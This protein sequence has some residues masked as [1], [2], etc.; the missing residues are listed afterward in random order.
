MSITDYLLKQKSVDELCAVGHLIDEFDQATHILDGLPEEYALVVMNIAANN[1]FAP[2]SVAYVHGLLLNME[3]RITRHRSSTSLGLE[4]T[5][6]ALLTPIDV[7]SSNC[8]WGSDFLPIVVVT[9]DVVLL[10]VVPHTPRP[11]LLPQVLHVA[12]HG[13]H[14]KF[15]TKGAILLW[16]AIIGWTRYT[17]DAT[18]L[19]NMLLWLLLISL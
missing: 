19:L 10:A 7:G 13:S 5:T 15:V 12:L 2:V 11:D 6:I 3:M 8:G 18:H 1:Q 16:T 14:V 9:E 4:Q 17:K